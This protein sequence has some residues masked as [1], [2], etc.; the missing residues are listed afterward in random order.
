MCR[1]RFLQKAIIEKTVV[2]AEWWGKK[3]VICKTLHTA[4]KTGGAGFLQGK[5]DMA[6]IDVMW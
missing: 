2:V 5:A 1:V 6:G 4:L 3:P